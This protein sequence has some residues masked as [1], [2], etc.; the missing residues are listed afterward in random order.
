MPCGDVGKGSTRTALG[1]GLEQTFPVSK[2]A[3]PRDGHVA[4]AGRLWLSTVSVESRS[5]ERGLCGP[6]GD[7]ALG[8][9]YEQ[10]L[11]Q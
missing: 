8:S 10:T 4:R 9:R 5:P 6:R 3:E 11:F 2:K 7:G 1:S